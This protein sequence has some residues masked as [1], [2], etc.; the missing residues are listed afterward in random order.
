MRGHRSG[1]SQAV[2]RLTAAGMS[3]LGSELRR[4]LKED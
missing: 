1:G 4:R 2:L 3:C